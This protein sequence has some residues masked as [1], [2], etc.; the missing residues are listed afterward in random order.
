MK[1]QHTTDL[2]KHAHEVP[3]AG[4]S[5]EKSDAP[6][7]MVL[8]AAGGLVLGGIVVYLVVSTMWHYLT[9]ADAQPSATPY[10]YGVLREPP[11]SPRLQVTP[12]V[13]WDRYRQDQMQTLGS[14]GWV[15]Q[16][17]GKV[18]IPIDRA[19]DILAQKGLP[20]RSGAPASTVQSAVKEA[21]EPASQ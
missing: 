12:Y 15:D 21:N 3:T 19:M 13:D 10:P 9:K 4:H 20:A 6:I 11:P 14:Y 2:R 8:T 18:R 7:R 1:D 16:G 5:H 17:A